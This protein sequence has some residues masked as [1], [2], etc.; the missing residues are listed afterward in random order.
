MSEIIAVHNEL[1]EAQNKITNVRRWLED[2]PT[3]DTLDESIASLI[4]CSMTLAK[5]KKD[6]VN[7]FSLEDK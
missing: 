6:I 7:H 2:R 3:A 5:V 1:H 4:L